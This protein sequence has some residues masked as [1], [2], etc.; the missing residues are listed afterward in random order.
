[1][2]EAAL[3]G[4]PVSIYDWPLRPARRFGPRAILSRCLSAAAGEQGAGAVR[5]YFYR[6]LE[7]LVD[8][9]LIKPPRDF[10][11]YHALLRERGL[12]SDTG[13]SI[14]AM[15]PQDVDLDRVLGAIRSLFN[16]TPE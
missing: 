8:I 10:R 13:A 12:L 14:S 6:G 4:K 1:M 3:T 7:N 16:G 11:H 15:K 5:R 2:I 9:G